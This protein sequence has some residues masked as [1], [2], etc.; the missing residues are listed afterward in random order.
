MRLPLFVSTDCF[1]STVL[2]YEVL[3]ALYNYASG[4]VTEEYSES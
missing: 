3:L 2:S 4:L 1:T